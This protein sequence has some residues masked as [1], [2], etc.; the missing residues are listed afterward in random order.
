MA[1]GS[2]LAL[3]DDIGTVLDD[4]AV[5]SKVAAK[6]TAGVLGDDLAL[7]A[8]QVTGVSADRELPVVWAVAK[9]S[10]LNK[11]ILVP[12]ALLISAFAPWAVTPLL[13][14]GGLFLCFEGVEKLAHRWLHSRAEDD[15][16]HAQLVRALEDPQVDLV[17]FEK[18]KIK[19]A[20]RT[21]FILSAEI[22][23]ITLGAVAGQPLTTQVLVLVGIALLMT[24]GVYGVVAGIVKL[25]DLGL[26]LERKA[27]AAVRAIGSGIVRATPWLMKALSV[28]GTAAMFLVGGGILV[29]GVSALHHW[30]EEA[31][32]EH[33]GFV[34]VLLTSL[35]DAAIGIAAG[36][37][38]LLGVKL[39]Q[40]MRGSRAVAH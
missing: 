1:T 9:G 23:A 34:D 6:K 2:L 18:E 7:N 25:D 14:V 17:A 40:R 21:D 8:Q 32:D 31:T 22:I 5:L 3:V 15:A 12:L 38:V 36:A 37:I 11:A 28:A 27:S 24:V 35:F 16:A 20:V 26:Y 39:V 19:G 10:L 13:M 4:V 29:H 33:V 30:I